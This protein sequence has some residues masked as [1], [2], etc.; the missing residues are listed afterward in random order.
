MVNNIARAS[1]ACIFVFFVWC[2]LSTNFVDE[3]ST[4]I[5]TLFR[6][7]TNCKLE[8]QNLTPCSAF[9]I[10]NYSYSDKN[11]LVYFHNHIPSHYLLKTH[12]LSVTITSKTNILIKCERKTQISA[13]GDENWEFRLKTFRFCLW[14]ISRMTYTVHTLRFL[15]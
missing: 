3:K 4:L 12:A 11:L 6:G 9:F 7:Y 2:L 15:L 8:T 5:M 14:R 1:L 10:I 13:D